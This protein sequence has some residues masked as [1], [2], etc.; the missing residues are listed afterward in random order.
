VKISA[1]NTAP[2]ATIASPVSTLNWKVGQTITFSGSASD[3]EDGTLPPSAFTW[4]LDTRHCPTVDTCHTH[5]VQTWTGVASGSF[6]APDHEYPSH[7]ELWLTVTDSGGLTDTKLVELYPQTNTLTVKSN[8]SGASIGVGSTVAPAPFT[9]TVIS[10][11][12]QSVAA[13]N[14][15]VNGTSYVF[16]GWS[17]GGVQSHQ[18]VV[19]SDTTLTATFKPG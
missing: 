11:S 4:T 10:G 3:A 1:G 8:P 17:D 15:T 7:L 5:P 6:V 9:L 18:I 14:Q 13:P 19:G 2:V 12:T 16:Q